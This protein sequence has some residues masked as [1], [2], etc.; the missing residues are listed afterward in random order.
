MKVEDNENTRKAPA[1]MLQLSCPDRNS[2]QASSSSARTAA[3]HAAGTIGDEGMLIKHLERLRSNT[4]ER[5]DIIIDEEARQ[6]RVLS[7]P[8]TLSQDPPA[9][10]A[11]TGT[12][13]I[14]FYKK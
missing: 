12:A 3:R 5:L 6:A 13:H 9:C 1:T 2:R 7:P 8:L 14:F 4:V 11:E 10:L